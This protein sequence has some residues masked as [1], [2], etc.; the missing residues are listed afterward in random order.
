MIDWCV[1][2]TYKGVERSVGAS[3]ALESQF[4]A[5]DALVSFGARAEC[6]V[7]GHVTTPTAAEALLAALAVVG[8]V[9]GRDPVAVKVI[10]DAE[11]ARRAESGDWPA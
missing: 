8:P 4:T 11:Q 9:V 7:T 1:T 6:D 10:T 5:L 3:I 2:L